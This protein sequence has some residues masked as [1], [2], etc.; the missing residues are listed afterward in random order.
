MV[1]TPYNFVLVIDK[2]FKVQ[3]ISNNQ[4]GLFYCKTRGHVES[5]KKIPSKSIC[6]TACGNYLRDACKIM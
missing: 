4:N 1:K 6:V 2:V 5:E 3:V